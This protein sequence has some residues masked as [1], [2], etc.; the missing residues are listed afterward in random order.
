MHLRPAPDWSHRAC[1]IDLVSPCSLLFPSLCPQASEGSSEV[2]FVE[3]GFETG[4]LSA[5]DTPLPREL[6]TI[7][8]AGKKYKVR[9]TPSTAGPFHS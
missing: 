3:L 8:L 1:L 7:Y 4:T 6:S 9:D 2:S 5:I